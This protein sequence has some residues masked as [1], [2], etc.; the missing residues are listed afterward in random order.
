[1]PAFDPFL[2]AAGLAI[3]CTAVAALRPIIAARRE[4]RAAARAARKRARRMRAELDALRETRRR[5]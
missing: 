1:M 3:G 5:A 4:V 2:L